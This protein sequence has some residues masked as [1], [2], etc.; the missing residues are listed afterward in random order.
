M[1]LQ[2][3]RKTGFLPLQLVLVVPFVLQISTAVSLTGWLSLRN[4]QKAVNNV[5]SQLRSEVS[6]RIQQRVFT[7]LDDPHL[8]NAVVAEAMEAGQI[9]VTDLP[10]LELYF[11]R[12]VDNRLVNYL[13]F[14][15]VD[16]YNVAVERVEERQ[17]VARYRDAATEPIREVHSL[18]AQ[19]SRIE[20]IKSKEYDPRTRPWYTTTVEANA[21]FWSPFYA[22]A[23]TSESVALLG[24]VC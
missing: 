9:D 8:V 18:D 15:S 5:A 1:V 19:G 6:D 12:L 14:G 17:L 13:Q 11:W 16:G 21:P 22:R 7:F 3:C 10:A 24:L 4:G 20:L 2:N 23:A